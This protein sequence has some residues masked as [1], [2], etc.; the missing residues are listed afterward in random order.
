M[1]TN[2]YDEIPK[3]ENMWAAYKQTI[4]GDNKY[5]RQAIKFSMNETYNLQELTEELKGHSY[6]FGGYSRSV[7]YEPKERIIDAPRLFRD[8]IVQIAINTVL[9]RLYQPC[10]IYDSYACLDGRGTHKCVNRIQH[11]LRKA[12]WEH[13]PDAF[14]IKT[15][16]KEF[17]YSIDRKIL[18]GILRKKIR[19]KR[20]LAL[21]DH[22]IDSADEISPIGLPLG[23][24]LSQLF[25]NIYL[26]ELDQYCKR[27]LRIRYYVR[28]MDDTIA[29]MPT[30]EEAQ[31]TLLQM[32]DFIEEEL[33]LSF[34]EKKT[35]IFPLDQGVNAVGFKIYPTHRLLR[36][37]SKK[38]IKRK[39][40][41]MPGL[42]KNGRMT[43]EKGN[44]MLSSW[45]GHADN[46]SSYNFM[47]N[48]LS[49]RSFLYIDKKSNLRIDKLK[50]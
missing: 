7:V 31:G 43:V 50:I 48:L 32:R 3:D 19:C 2:L 40:K 22:I 5:A 41:K 44:Q 18:K 1:P 30:K 9:K 11:F 13:G 42:I 16:V 36:N 12:K 24:T 28:Y 33:S 17:F 6:R 34:N 46:G 4:K 27:K 8:K 49:K 21:L 25:G 10:F 38:K 23:N 20:T 29:V 45:Q 39:T 26:N 35:K 14:I 37:D 47:N 15:D